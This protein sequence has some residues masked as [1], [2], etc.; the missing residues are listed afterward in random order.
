MSVHLESLCC[1]WRREKLASNGTALAIA[2]TATR[3]LKSIVYMHK[4]GLACL[5]LDKQQQQHRLASN[6]KEIKHLL[7]VA[8]YIRS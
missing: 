7:V 8:I 3:R 6:R 1:I 4:M 2:E 5:L